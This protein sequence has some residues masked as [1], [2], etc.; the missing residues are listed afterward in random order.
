LL[1]N[2][3]QQIS[4]AQQPRKGPGCDLG[5]FAGLLDMRQEAPRWLVLAD[6]G[7][8]PSQPSAAF[9]NAWGPRVII[10]ASAGV[11]Q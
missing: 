5:F 1:W 4:L 7:L 10:P 3:Q 11:S 9:V 2:L 8:T 6:S